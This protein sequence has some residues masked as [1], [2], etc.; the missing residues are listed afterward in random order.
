VFARSIS[1]GCRRGGD[2]ACTSEKRWYSPPRSV[3]DDLGRV[4]DLEREREADRLGDLLLP[5]IWLGSP[6]SRSSM[7]TSRERMKERGYCCGR[8]LWVIRCEEN[9]CEV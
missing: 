6:V 4:I 8:G 7:V 3:L 1:I 2:E 5:L 9:L